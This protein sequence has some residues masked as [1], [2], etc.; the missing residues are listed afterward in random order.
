MRVLPASMSVSPRHRARRRETLV[1]IPPACGPGDA[2]CRRWTRHRHDSQ[3]SSL[4]SLV[5]LPISRAAGCCCDARSPMEQGI[6]TARAT[7]IDPET[8][9]NPGPKP[10]S[11]G[12][13]SD[14][15]KSDNCLVLSVDVRG[16]LP[17]SAGDRQGVFPLPS[18]LPSNPSRKY[19]RPRRVAGRRAEATPAANVRICRRRQD[20]RSRRAT[21]DICRDACSP[22]QPPGVGRDQGSSS[23]L[24]AQPCRQAQPTWSPDARRVVYTSGNGLWV[25]DSNGRNAHEIMHRRSGRNGTERGR[26]YDPD[27]LT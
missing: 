25:V 13:P 15:H 14:P 27:C 16:R 1:D 11:C 4:R 22:P 7:T 8:D 3:T 18:K 21:P 5:R 23:T 10:L 9:Q 2:H 19:S 24:L 12:Q 6:P 17:S 26:P 20:V